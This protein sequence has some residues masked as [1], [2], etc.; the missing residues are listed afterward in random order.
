MTPI[1]LAVEH[2]LLVAGAWYPGMRAEI[3][4]AIDGDAEPD[5]DKIREQITLQ[6]KEHPERFLPDKEHREVMGTDD[7]AERLLKAVA[8]IEKTRFHFLRSL[9][10]IRESEPERTTRSA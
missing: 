9:Q 4:G 7:P 6:R 2:E 5:V 10:S 8:S 3:V 1:E